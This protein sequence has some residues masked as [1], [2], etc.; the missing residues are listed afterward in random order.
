M[1]QPTDIQWPPAAARLGRGF[2]GPSGLTAKPRGGG[3]A[4]TAS[5]RDKVLVEPTG[6]AA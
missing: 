5:K 4:R 6:A 2:M 1:T 3:F